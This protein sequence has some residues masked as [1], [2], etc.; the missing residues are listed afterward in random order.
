[1][2]KSGSREAELAAGGVMRVDAT[3]ADIG[4]AI[5]IV[6]IH[7]FVAFGFVAQISNATQQFALK[8]VGLKLWRHIHPAELMDASLLFIRSSFR[9]AF[10]I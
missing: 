10:Q 1:M 5:G 4:E 8:G 7:V 3:G 2:R 6:P 9:F